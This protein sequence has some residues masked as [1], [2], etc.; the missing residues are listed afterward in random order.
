[1]ERREEKRERKMSR[2]SRLTVMGNILFL[3]KRGRKK[4]SWR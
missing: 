2:V 4:K 3:I 1:M